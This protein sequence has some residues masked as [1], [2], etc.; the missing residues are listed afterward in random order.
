MIALIFSI[1]PILY[2]DMQSQISNE[3]HLCFLVDF[4]YLFFLRLLLNI[5]SSL[6]IRYYVSAFTE[7]DGLWHWY[8]NKVLTDNGLV[9]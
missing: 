9:V 4:M 7:L 1:Y 2:P 6:H 5:S 3:P 8:E